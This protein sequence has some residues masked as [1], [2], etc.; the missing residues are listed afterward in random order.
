MDKVERRRM[1]GDKGET[2]N[3]KGLLKSSVEMN[4]IGASK[5]ACIH[6]GDI[7]EIMNSS[8]RQIPNWTSLMTKRCY[9]TGNDLHLIEFLAKGV[10]WEVLNNPSCC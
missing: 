10:S 1:E 4:T 8:G 7:N 5:N 2:T 3:I 6:I 9:S